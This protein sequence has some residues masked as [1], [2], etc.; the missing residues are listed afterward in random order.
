MIYRGQNS[1]TSGEAD[2]ERLMYG[3]F[4]TDDMLRQNDL[5]VL[6]VPPQVALKMPEIVLRMVVS[7]HITWKDLCLR[8]VLTML[9]GFSPQWYYSR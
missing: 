7:L 3:Y 8:S 1:S 2:S 9:P 6:S 4:G 5:A